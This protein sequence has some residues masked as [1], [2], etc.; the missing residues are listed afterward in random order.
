ML[1]TYSIAMAEMS[2]I[3]A[4]EWKGIKGFGEGVPRW[5]SYKSIFSHYLFCASDHLGFK[6]MFRSVAHPAFDL[7]LDH[8][9]ID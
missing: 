1:E 2:I 6:V 8:T 9:E 4:R 3:G 7:Q 5:R